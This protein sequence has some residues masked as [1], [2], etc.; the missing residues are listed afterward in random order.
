MA[1]FNV[2]RAHLKFACD[3]RNWDLLDKLLE[4]DASRIDDNS[5]Y[6]DTWGS[7]WGLLMEAARLG[8]IDGVKVL[9]KHGAKRD[10]AC[11]GDGI[12]QAPLEMAQ[13]F[14]EIIAL[15]TSPD[16]PTY[17]RTT[18]PPL[19]QSDSPDDVAVNR[20]GV[21]RDKTGIVFQTP[22]LEPRKPD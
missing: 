14:P 17:V 13:E 12:E 9:L 19:P 5:L 8:A 4:I 7:W 2:T 18:D 1:T 11:W 6:T 15:L 3:H 16:V 22:N 10:L 20:Q 21:I